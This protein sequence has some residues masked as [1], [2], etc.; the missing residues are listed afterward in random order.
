M[1]IKSGLLP[2]KIS[3]DLARR[4]PE[5]QRA[6]AHRHHRRGHPAPLEVAQQ[7][8]PA[9][10]ALPVAILD[11]EQ[12]SRSP[13]NITRLTACWEKEYTAFRQRD[14]RSDTAAVRRLLH[15]QAAQIRYQCSREISFS[16]KGLAPLPS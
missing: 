13:T 11:R 7:C 3:G 14:Q 1:L 8:L 12:R 2:N 15:P 16:G 4:G 9:L 6:V 10:G 5:A